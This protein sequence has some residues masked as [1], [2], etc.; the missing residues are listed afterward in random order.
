MSWALA[1]WVALNMANPR[2]VRIDPRCHH[3]PLVKGCY[4]ERNP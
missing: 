3:A 4:P 2:Y 1:V